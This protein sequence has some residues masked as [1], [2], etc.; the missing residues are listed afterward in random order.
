[1][2]QVAVKEAHNTK[3][4][5]IGLIGAKKPYTL[6]IKTRW[7][8]HTFGVQFPIDI[9]VLDKENKV[10]KMKNSLKPN[11]IFFWHPKYLTVIELPEGFVEK[12]KIKLQEKIQIEYC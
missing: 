2:I 5:V 10:V 1:M 6:L 11:R 7:G 8:I 4:K 3:D 12:K 9:L